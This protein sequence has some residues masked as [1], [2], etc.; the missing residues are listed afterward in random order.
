[1]NLLALDTATEACSAALLCGG[2]V[3]ARFEA[4]SR[5]HTEKLAPMVRGLMAEAG[6]G[7][8]QLDG[9]ACGVGPGSFAGVRIGVSFVKG[10]ALA[11][12]RPV[13]GVSS[14]AMLAL[15]LLQAGASRV[16]TAIDARMDEIYFAAWQAGADGL[17]TVVGDE[18]VCAPQ[19]AGHWPGEW[20]AA[21]TGWRYAEAL[22]AATG[23]T[24][25]SVDDQALPRAEHALTIARA[26]FAAGRTV[27]AAELLPRYLRNKV[28]LTLREQQQ[29]RAAKGTP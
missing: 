3:V 23:A 24:L 22:R 1:M 2:Q 21:G 13:V 6:L 26:A 5:G 28:A 25:A 16:L 27:A 17:P 15:P 4:T 18:Q 8:A 19:D 9:Y 11:H 10:L 12:A 29:A 14:L 7:F 20:A